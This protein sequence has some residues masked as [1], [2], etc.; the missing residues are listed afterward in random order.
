MTT[1]HNITIEHGA[2]FESDNGEEVQRLA[3]QV[4]QNIEPALEELELEEDDSSS[5]IT[6]SIFDV[7]MMCGNYTLSPTPDSSMLTF[8]PTDDS[9]SM[10]TRHVHRGNYSWSPYSATLTVFSLKAIK[11]IDT[12]F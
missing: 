2:F 9:G 3:S 11:V 10:N 12:I 7:I 5:L 6:I 1:I 8:G 4:A